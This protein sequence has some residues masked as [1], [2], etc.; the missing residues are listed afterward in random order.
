MTMGDDAELHSRCPHITL[1]MQSADRGV[2]LFRIRRLMP[3]G[4]LKDAYCS[5][6]GLAKD[7]AMLSFDGEQISDSETANSLE[8]EDED[9]MDVQM[10]R[11][12]EAGDAPVRALDLSI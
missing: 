5:Q 9:I 10:K 8:L 3:L 11:Q 7:M 1:K 2:V 4:K 12:S 6:M